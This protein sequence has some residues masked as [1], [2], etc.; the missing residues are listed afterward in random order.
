MGVVATGKRVSFTPMTMDDK[1]RRDRSVHY[2]HDMMSVFVKCEFIVVFILLLPRYR[3]RECLDADP[4]IFRVPPWHFVIFVLR[5][6]INCGVGLV[7]CFFRVPLMYQPCCL[8]PCCQ[9]KL[10]ELTKK[11]FTKP[12]PQF[13]LGRSIA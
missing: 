3:Y 9:G 7:N 1:G 11:Q 10:G 4:C 2:E 13:I 5:P 12:T 6:K 8:L